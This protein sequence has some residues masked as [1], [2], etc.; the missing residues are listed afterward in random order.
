MEVFAGKHFIFRN[1][2]LTEAF[3]ETSEEEVID[4]EGLMVI[5]GLVDIHSHGAY[6]EDFSDGDPEGL[7]K[8]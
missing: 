2:R 1:H 5:P 4:A 8:S 6:G 7:K 3:E